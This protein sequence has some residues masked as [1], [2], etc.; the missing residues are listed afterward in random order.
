MYCTTNNASDIILKSKL[1]SHTNTKIIIIVMGWMKQ[2]VSVS[3]TDVSWLQIVCYVNGVNFVCQ[4]RVSEMNAL[5]LSS[6]V[7]GD[8]SRIYND[9][10]ARD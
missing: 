6:G 3:T 2:K 8:S 10:N 4:E 5:F 1:P 7:D 9:H